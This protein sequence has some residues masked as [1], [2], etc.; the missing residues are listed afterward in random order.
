MLSFVSKKASLV[1]GVYSPEW[2][3]GQMGQRV[4]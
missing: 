4:T 3:M 1:N 2:T